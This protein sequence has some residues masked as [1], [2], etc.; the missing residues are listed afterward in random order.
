MYLE[1]PIKMSGTAVQ[2]GTIPFSYPFS[3]EIINAPRYGKV[4][5]P[6][7]ELYDG[8]TDLEEHLGVHKAQMYIQDV[9]NAAYCCYLPATLKG[10]AESW[11]NGL[12]PGSVSCFQDLSYRFLSQF[13]ASRKKRQTSIHLSK[14]V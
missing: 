1:T 11:F 13:I 7:V 12:A 8:T 3:L 6:T 14:I 5:M 10:G 9:D 4:K 2:M